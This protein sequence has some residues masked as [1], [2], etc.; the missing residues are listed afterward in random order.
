MERMVFARLR[1]LRGGFLLA[2]GDTRAGPRVYG[3]CAWG[4][5]L[6][7]RNDRGEDRVVACPTN[8]QERLISDHGD[9]DGDSDGNDGRGGGESGRRARGG[10]GRACPSVL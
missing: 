7:E 9:G 10:G 3:V 2:A 4:V 5:V 1:E 6:P 8:E